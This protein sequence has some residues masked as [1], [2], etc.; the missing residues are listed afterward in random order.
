VKKGTVFLSLVLLVACGAL[1][2]GSGW[3]GLVGAFVGTSLGVGAVAIAERLD[4]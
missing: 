3:L 2:L 1:L 4:Q